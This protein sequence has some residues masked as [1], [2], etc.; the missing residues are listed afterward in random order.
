MVEVMIHHANT[1]LWGR[2]KCNSMPSLQWDD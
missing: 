2:W 1:T